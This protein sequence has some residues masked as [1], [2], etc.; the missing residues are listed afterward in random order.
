MS[1]IK[2]LAA[3]V[4][5]EGPIPYQPHFSMVS[6]D[7]R[8]CEGA[9]WSPSL[10]RPHSHDLIPPQFPPPGP[11][12]P[13]ARLQH[14]HLGRCRHSDRSLLFFLFRVGAGRRMMRWDRSLAAVA[15]LCWRPVG[16]RQ[17][18]GSELMPMFGF[19][20]VLQGMFREFFH[21]VSVAGVSASG[22]HY[23]TFPVTQ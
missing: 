8:W 19:A 3:L 7:G 4:C 9:L 5:S 1:E 17:L 13:G 12:T 20:E 22:I 10:M 21:E 2:V 6:S 11:S 14:M 18:A 23:V 16:C 15:L